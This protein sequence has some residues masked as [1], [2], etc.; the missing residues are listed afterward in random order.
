MKFYKIHISLVISV[1]S[2]LRF[3]LSLNKLSYKIKH[4]FICYY[5]THTFSRTFFVAEECFQEEFRVR[6]KK[7]KLAYTWKVD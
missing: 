5:L 2:F 1:T 4:V 3:L 6:E 7:R